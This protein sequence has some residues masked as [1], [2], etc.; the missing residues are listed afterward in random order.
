MSAQSP[1]SVSSEI[2]AVTVYRTGAEVRRSA[3]I[4]LPGGRQTLVLG[5]I[6]AELVRESLQVTC[7]DSSILLLSVRHRHRYGTRPTDTDRQREADAEMEALLAR[8]RLLRTRI[9][10]G[11]EEEA[12]L[13]ANRDLGGT[14]TGL[15][16][17]DLERGVRYHRERLAAIRLDRLAMQDSLRQIDD[18]RKGIASRLSAFLPDTLPDVF[19]EV[20]VELESRGPITDSIFLSYVV[21]DAGW[22]PA[23]D[24]RVSEL[25]RP[26][27]LDFS[28]RVGQRT[29]EDWTDVS[30][31]LSTG[32]PK[33]SARVPELQ[34]WR[35]APY[36]M[37]PIYDRRDPGLVLT[38]VGTVTGYVR[39][40]G[41]LPLVGVTISMPGENIGTVTDL[42]GSFSLSVPRDTRTLTVSYLGYEDQSVP[43]T[44]RELTIDL[45]PQTNALDEVVVTGYGQASMLR[46]LGGKLNGVSRTTGPPPVPTIVDRQ[47]TT[48]RYELDTPFSVP[49]DTT[50]RVVRIENYRVP[51]SYRHTAVPKVDERVFLS[52]VIRDWEAYDLLSGDLQLFVGGAFVATSWLDADRTSDSLIISLGADPGVIIR[53]ESIER[54]SKQTGLFGGRRSVWRGWELEA[55]NTKRVPIDLVVYDQ[56][57][58]SANA[59]IDVYTKLPDAAT[60]TAESGLLEWRFTLAPRESWQS[61]FAYEVRYAT[62]GPVYLE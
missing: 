29:G 35:L 46:Q 38:T 55:R 50:A 51:A 2:E 37:P 12:V 6:T 32:D 39:D 18:A 36:Q 57:P 53:R 26:L 42:D 31:T 5:G 3:A 27:N 61:E 58:V 28:A 11:E 10:I 21:G 9:A 34:T 19:S 14:A 16:A 44:G 62:Q 47:P 15:N 33:R 23:Y 17:E 13:Q 30:L 4:R 60:Y 52:A 43:I 54:Y 56:V 40:E 24:L 1:L 45:I 8:E 49:S 41:G 48:L 59:N 20:V 25:D 22:E 7:P